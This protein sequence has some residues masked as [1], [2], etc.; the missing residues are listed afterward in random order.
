MTPVQLFYFLNPLHSLEQFGTSAPLSARELNDVMEQLRTY[1]T[2]EIREF[3]ELF[4][5]NTLRSAINEQ[6]V[7]SYSVPLFTDSNYEDVKLLFKE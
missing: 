3:A 1:S 6:R 4:N 5:T 2:S 7:E